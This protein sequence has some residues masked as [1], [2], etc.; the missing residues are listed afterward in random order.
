MSPKCLIA[1]SYKDIRLAIQNYIY[2]KK[3][4]VTA[5]RAKFLSVIQAVGESSDDFL[6]RLR[7]ESRNCD[8]EKIKSGTKPEKELMKIYFISRL[9]DLEA[10]LRLLD[11]IKEAKPAMRLT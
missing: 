5:E 11:G 9:R 4:V 2:P 7:E 3:R 10:K 6:V 8:F 1:A